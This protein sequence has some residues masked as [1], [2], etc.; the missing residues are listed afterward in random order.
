MIIDATWIAVGTSRGYIALWD[1]RFQ[2]LVKVWRHASHGPIFSLELSGSPMKDVSTDSGHVASCRPLVYVAAGDNEAAAFDL[3]NGACRGLFR[4]LGPHVEEAEARR[5]VS[6]EHVAHRSVKGSPVTLV[7]PGAYKEALNDLQYAA[8]G[9]NAVRTILCP[10]N[11]LRGVSFGLVTAGEDR[12]I[13][14]WDL[15][16]P[17]QSFTISGL[18]PGTPASFYDCQQ[19]PTGWWRDKHGADWLEKTSHNG[20]KSPMAKLVPPMVYMCQDATVPHSP[21]F[22]PAV[23]RSGPVPPSPSHSDC[24]LDLKMLDLHSPMIASCGRDGLIKIWG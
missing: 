12:Q 21:S 19:A 5:C 18:P 9:R 24:V 3:T 17:K 13:R 1:I 23:E 16:H 6:L 15:R 22:N 11:T 2:L 10:S 7:S 14:Y 4:S 20:S 8:S